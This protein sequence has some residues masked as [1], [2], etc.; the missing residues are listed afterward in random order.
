MKLAKK[1]ISPKRDEKRT[2]DEL[3]LGLA[4]HLVHAD[5]ELCPNF[6]FNLL[7][8]DARK[9]EGQYK[10]VEL[11]DFWL[12]P[13]GVYDEPQRL[14][15]RHD[16]VG[17]VVLA[18]EKLLRRTKRSK[19]RNARAVFL[20]ATLAKFFEYIWI[21][22]RFDL[23]AILPEDFGELARALAHGGW[24]EA[25]MVEERLTN[26]LAA[27]GHELACQLISIGKNHLNNVPE[28]AL[29]PTI[30]TNI[31]ARE[32]AVYRKLILQHYEDRLNPRARAILAS[33]DV[34]KKGM[35]RSMLRQTLSM[36]NL[37]IDL[38]APYGVKFLPFANP[39]NL[40]NK[41]TKPSG[42]TRNLGAVEAGALLSEGYIGGFIATAET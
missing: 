9:D 18:A 16:F 15:N 38:P 11:S 28:D 10:N 37:L 35:K 4:E 40:A 17:S 30:G 22:N 1:A 19:T 21:K 27:R 32:G 6:S 14:T 12:P 25:L 41:L 2:P 3:F 7:K 31:A 42:A 20:T 5:I 13:N 26:A 8:T 29:G 33:E 34:P 36:I 24:H 23:K 39:T